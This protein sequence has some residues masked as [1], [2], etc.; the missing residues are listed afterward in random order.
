MIHSCASN[1]TRA[2]VIITAR[3]VCTTCSTTR[4]TRS[5]SPL[6]SPPSSER[7]RVSCGTPSGP[8]PRRT[9]RSHDRKRVAEGWKPARRDAGGLA[10]SSER[11]RR[12]RTASA[13]TRV[14]RYVIGLWPT[15][16]G[17]TCNAIF[18]CSFIFF[19]TSKTARG[20]R[21]F[22]VTGRARRYLLHDFL[23]RSQARTIKNKFRKSRTPR[24]FWNLE[25]HFFSFFPFSPGSHAN[26]LFRHVSRT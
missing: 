26:V 24:R 13:N 19:P 15:T 16:H 9:V 10:E 25:N 6:C 14:S 20:K 17:I 5:A 2:H 7:A 8:P 12:K 1:L 21:D 22:F 11:A 23:A 18:Y 3:N 4:Y